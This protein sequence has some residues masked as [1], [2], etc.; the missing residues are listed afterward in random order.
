[1][2]QELIQKN[3]EMATKK[4]L[5]AKYFVLTETYGTIS[6][7]RQTISSTLIH[8][9]VENGKQFNRT[10]VDRVQTHLRLNYNVT[11]STK[12]THDKKVKKMLL[13]NDINDYEEISK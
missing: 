8:A 3:I 7:N 4:N 11:K 12:E 10:Y 6:G 5:S 9:I 13:K 2:N 1:M